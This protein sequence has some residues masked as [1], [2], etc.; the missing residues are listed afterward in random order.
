MGYLL[1]IGSLYSR[2]LSCGIKDYII[3]KNLLHVGDEYL[4]SCIGFYFISHEIRIHKPT[5]ISLQCQPRALITAHLKMMEW[6]PSSES[7]TVSHGFCSSF[8]VNKNLRGVFCCCF[9]FNIS[10]FFSML[11]LPFPCL[12]LIAPGCFVFR[13]NGI[14]CFQGPKKR[15]TT[16]G[17]AEKSP[18]LKGLHHGSTKRDG[19]SPRLGVPSKGAV[20]AAKN[21]GQ[22]FFSLFFF[23]RFLGSV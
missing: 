11:K 21:Q 7:P 1:Y 9:C 12:V 23:E 2:T 3:F 6:F 5:R 14:W 17:D 18:L 8:H 16:G 4:P 19:S 20:W 10:V 15:R 22:S 13:P